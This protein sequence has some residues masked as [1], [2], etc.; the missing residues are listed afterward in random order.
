MKRIRK[1]FQPAARTAAVLFAGIFLLLGSM[2][3][4]IWR[5]YK[6]SIID[7]QKSQMLLLVQS[8]GVHLKATIQSYTSDLEGLYEMEDLAEAEVRAGDWK[9]LRDYAESHAPVVWDVMLETGE[10]EVVE[11]SQGDRVLEMYS[12]LQINDTV[13]LCQ[14][15]MEKGKTGLM[16]RKELRQGGYLSIILD[17]KQYYDEVISV[18]RPG[19]N[20]YL[21]VKDSAGTIL[22]HPAE[23]QWGIDTIEGRHELYPK[24][25]LT[26]LEKL[27]ESQMKGEE[28]V[29]EYESYWWQ[30]PDMPRVRKISAYTPVKTGEDFLVVSAVMDYSD[31]YIPIARGVRQLVLAF[32]GFTAAVVILAFYMGSLLR[33]KKRDK[34]EIGY[35]QELNRI[36]EEMHRSEE[37]I[38]HQQRLQII[39]T[40]TGGIA[41]EFNNLLT[42]IMGYADLLLAELPEESEAYEEASEIYDA[43]AK[44]RDMIQQISSLSRKNMETAFKQLPAA[45][46][47]QRAVKMVRSVCPANVELEASLELGD[48]RILG[49]ETQLN[50]AVLNICVNA[51]HAIGRKPEGRLC[52]LGEVVGREDLRQWKLSAIPENWN[53]YIRLT[54]RDNGCGM[55]RKVMEQIF[56]PFF[57]TKENGMGT[58]LGL[59]L[60]EQIIHSHK[61]FVFVESE[62]GQGSSFFIYLPVNEKNEPKEAEGK[63]KKELRLL[64]AD[65]NAKVLKLLERNFARLGIRVDGC[66]SFEEARKQLEK[67][68]YDVMAVEQTIAG[69][70]AV[71]FYMAVCGLQPGM[72]RLVMADQVT[73]ELAEAKERRIIDSYIDKP[74]SDSSIL[75]AVRRIRKE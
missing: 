62:E 60:V 35:L 27:I 6:Q 29:M 33:Q 48:T 40:M 1:K 8:M 25:D 7:N 64:I 22:M 46:I 18:I 26:S 57:T 47:I 9:L 39:G 32:T 72:V 69:E 30:Q 21:V 43:S 13:S 52:L 63:E 17:G 38:A 71:D 4:G 75:D 19:T 20:S 34:E 31:I 59:A 24:A 15:V 53:R 68:A 5:E 42:P 28:G 36:L 41:H 67:Q 23:V 65:D 66:M 45:R 3:I 54:V 49:N 37:T 11:S 61:G 12:S 74:V 14:A 16:F 51:I 70:S 56:D 55:S 10:G 50:Q 2:G 73:K 58:G 44:A